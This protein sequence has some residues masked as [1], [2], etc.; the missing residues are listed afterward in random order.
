MEA[1]AE[2][3]VVASTDERPALVVVVLTALSLVLSEELTLMLDVVVM[4][5]AEE[6]E[7]AEKALVVDAD[8]LPSQVATAGPGM[9]YDFPPLVGL[10]SL[11]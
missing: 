5:A 2:G 9:V 10:P 7:V 11:P 4:E 3:L 6:D 1:E 8:E